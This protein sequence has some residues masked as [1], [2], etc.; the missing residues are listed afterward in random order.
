M[1]LIPFGGGTS[2]TRALEVPP[3]NIEPRPV[4]SVDMRKVCAS[5]CVLV[6]EGP[7]VVSRESLPSLRGETTPSRV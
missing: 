2:V 4:L 7:A 5:F 6:N 1:C 3:L